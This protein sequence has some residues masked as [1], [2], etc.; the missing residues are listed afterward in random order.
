M[1]NALFN[2]LVIFSLSFTLSLSA[3]ASP[4]IGAEAPAFTATTSN[5]QEISLESFRGKPVM[6]EWTNHDC[7]FVRKHYES[8]NMQRTQRSL[9]EEGVVW[10]SVISSAPGEQGHVS[11]NEANALTTS[12]GAYANH[13]I[14]DPSGTIGRLYAAKTTPHMFLIDE[15]GI[16]KYMGAIDDRPSARASSLE[17]ATNYVLAAWEALKSGEAIENTN[18]KPYGCSVKYSAGH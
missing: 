3:A 14:L 15:E 4:E 12:R 8:G 7:P 17:G 6:L 13:V 16:L 1:K 10:L 2:I 5:G 9:T 18:T 11:P